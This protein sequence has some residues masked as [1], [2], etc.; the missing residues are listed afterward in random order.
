METVNNDLFYTRLPVNEIPLGEL[1]MEEHLFYPM[2]RNWYVVITD[3]KNSTAAVKEGFYQTINLVATGSIVAVLNIAYKVNLTVP[4]FFG[5]D[6][7]TL[8]IPPS[9][10]DNTM[11]ALMK[12]R[13]NT[14]TNFKLDLRVG[15][16]SI[17]EIYDRGLTIHISKLKTSDLFAIP[18]L[19][20]NGLNYAEKKIK[21]PDY[22]FNLNPSLE[23]VDLSGMQCRWDR[24]KPPADNQEVVSLIVFSRD[25]VKQSTLLKK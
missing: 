14:M 16:V 8:I 22:L 25:G 24:I 5:G 4:F 18:V 7:A 1:L 3:V 6:G 12:H 17:A 15:Y 20:G 9:I 13:E 11:E 21:G 2:P 10:F 19:L 23:E